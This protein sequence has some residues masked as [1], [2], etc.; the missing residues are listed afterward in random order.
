MGPL[1]V[2]MFW[3]FV[4]F[5]LSVLGGGALVAIVAWLLRGIATGRGKAL[6]IAGCLP[7]LGFFYMFI[8]VIVFS[9][10]STSRGRDM[11]WG[12]SW[13]TPILGNYHLVMID[14][15]DIGTICNSA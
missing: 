4:A 10:W 12:D 5:V 8:C 11:G 9:I 14:L 6:L 15:T 3:G 1:F 2:F 7:A 13:D